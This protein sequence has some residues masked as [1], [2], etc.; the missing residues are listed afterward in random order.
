MEKWYRYKTVYIFLALLASS[1]HRD[2]SI[3]QRQVVLNNLLGNRNLH[4]SKARIYALVL[5]SPL[6]LQIKEVFI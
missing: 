1:Q 6:K 3:L 4:R 5:C 2:V